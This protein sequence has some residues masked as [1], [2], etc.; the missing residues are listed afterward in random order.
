MI[1]NDAFKILCEGGTFTLGFVNSELEKLGWPESIMDEEGFDLV[2]SL[3]VTEF[4]YSVNTRVN[5]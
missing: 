3:I 1:R 5:E 4:D 2:M